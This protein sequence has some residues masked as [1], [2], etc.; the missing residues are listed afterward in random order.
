MFRG[1]PECNRK[2]YSPVGLSIEVGDRAG[3]M[4][5]SVPIRLILAHAQHKYA[6]GGES[7]GES[8]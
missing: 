5:M 2:L 7:P 8:G 6:I 4:G 1:Q 3:N